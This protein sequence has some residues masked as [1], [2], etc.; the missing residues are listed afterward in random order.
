MDLAKAD[1]FGGGRGGWKGQNKS[2][3]G[4]LIK[5]SG[6]NRLDRVDIFFSLKSRYILFLFLKKQT[7]QKKSE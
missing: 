1:V 4:W 3:K 6:K 2:K 7:L 5:P